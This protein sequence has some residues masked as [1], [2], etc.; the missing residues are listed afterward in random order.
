MTEGG[1]G[2]ISIYSGLF[3]NIRKRRQFSYLYDPK[4]GRTGPILFGGAHY[5]L[6]NRTCGTTFEVGGGADR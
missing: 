4:H 2:P 3:M 5:C 6:P 1:G